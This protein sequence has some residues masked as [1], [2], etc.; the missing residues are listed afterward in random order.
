[1]IKRHR[2][3]GDD[4]AYKGRTRIKEL[5]IG[6]ADVYIHPMYGEFPRTSSTCGIIQTVRRR[7]R[8]RL[9]TTTGRSISN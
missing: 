5:A 6:H 1:L 4:F 8:R 9:P 2:T 7:P 3:A